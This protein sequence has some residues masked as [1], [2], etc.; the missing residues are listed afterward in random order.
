MGAAAPF[1]KPEGTPR[2]G[3]PGWSAGGPMVWM[4]MFATLVLA[5]M[6][7][8]DVRQT[9]LNLGAARFPSPAGRTPRR[10]ADCQDGVPSLS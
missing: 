6:I 5:V 4:F 3:P 7:S 9:H 2:P 1:T 10:R 8:F